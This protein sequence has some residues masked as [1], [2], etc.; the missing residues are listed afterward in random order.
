MPSRCE[1]FRGTVSCWC[2]N[3]RRSRPPTSARFTRTSSVATTPSSS[4]GWSS[5]SPAESLPANSSTCRMRCSV[6]PG[7]ETSWRPTRPIRATTACSRACP[8]CARC[9]RRSSARAGAG[10][11]RRQLQPRADARR[12]R[13]RAA[14]GHCRQPASVGAGVA[15]R[16]PLPGARATTGI[17]RICQDF[18]I[19]MIPVPIDRRRARTWTSSSGW[20]PRTRRS[21]AC[22]ACRSTATRPAPSTRDATVERLAAMATA[23]PDFRIF[24]D[25]AYAVHHLT[26]ERIEIAEHRSTRARAHGHP[27]RAFVFGSTSKVTLAGAGVG[28]VR[29]VAGE[30]GVVPEPHGQADH[31]RRQDQPAAPRARSCATPTGSLALMDRH[32]A[33]VA[34]KFATVV[35]VFARASRRHRRRHVDRARRAATSSASTCWTAARARSSSWRRRP[36]SR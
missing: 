33:I 6:C 26:D 16:V 10:R 2:L 25:N 32:R 24:W 34:P 3:S 23:A 7:A 29:G 30:R 22:G 14:Q 9:S 11:A 12:D 35:D 8:N 18:G 20:S 1:T 27:H 31:R 13:L 36:A 28:A 15:R 5:I 19:E 21:R 4:V 17:S